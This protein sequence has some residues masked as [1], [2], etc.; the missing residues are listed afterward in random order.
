MEATA[1]ALVDGDVM[2]RVLSHGELVIESHQDHGSG[3]VLG[4]GLSRKSM[5]PRELIKNKHQKL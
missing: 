2:G 5:D 1:L 3:P 4:V